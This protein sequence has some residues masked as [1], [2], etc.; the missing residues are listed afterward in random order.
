MRAIVVTESSQIAEARQVAS[1]LATA[2]GFDDTNAGRV[3]LVATELATNIVKHGGGGELLISDYD[4]GSVGGVQLIALDKGK[5]IGNLAQSF[6]DGYS[7]AGTAG[8]G[9]GAIRRQSQMVNIATWPGR[10]TAVLVH[11][12]ADGKPA[13]GPP[14]MPVCGCI[15]IPIH[16]EEICGDDC[17]SVDTQAGLTLIVADGLGHGPEAA[18]A[19]NEAVRLFQSHKARP[20]AELL[21]YIHNGLRATRG[22]AIAIARLDRQRSRVQYGG[23]GNIAG[24]IIAPEG[25]RRM[26][27][28]NGTAGHNARKILAFDYAWTTGIVVMHSDGLGT[29]WSLDRYPGLAQ[30]HPTLIASVLYRDF[31]RGRDDVTVLVARPAANA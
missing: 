1:Q 2:L 5:G 11:I 18:A 4:A 21:D 10:G 9:L 12:S 6:E 31:T 28:L 25:V 15:A 23:I 24:A 16:G 19:A 7:S 17:A 3:A 13:A 14:I 29:S 20:I 30:M 26:V 27:S 22:A 8:H